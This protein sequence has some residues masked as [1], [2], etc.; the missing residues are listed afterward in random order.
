MF[1]GKFIK[2]KS[3]PFGHSA[4][5]IFPF[6]LFRHRLPEW[7]LQHERIHLRQQIELLI[8]PFYI[9]YFLEFMIRY[10]QTGQRLQAYKSISFEREA[11]KNDHNLN[12]LSERKVWNFLRYVKK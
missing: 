6:I 5:T 7:L 11:Y 10:L 8:L 2:V 9:W 4:M 12:Y 1:K 3:L